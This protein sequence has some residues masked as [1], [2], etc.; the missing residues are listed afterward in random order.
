MR[1]IKSHIIAKIYCLDPWKSTCMRTFFFFVTICFFILDV[2][3]AAEESWP[4]LR[5]RSL[6]RIPVKKKPPFQKEN[7]SNMFINLSN[8]SYTLFLT[9]LW[10]SYPCLL[11]NHY[12][13]VLMKRSAYTSDWF[14]YNENV[15]YK[16]YFYIFNATVQLKK[17]F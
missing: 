1:K 12:H 17:A 4:W 6:T 9:S 2:F 11:L 8:V 15:P 13:I 16:F 14:W 3:L 5:K 7:S 10:V